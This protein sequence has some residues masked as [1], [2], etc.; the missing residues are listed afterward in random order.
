VHS[1]SY[2]LT[3]QVYLIWLLYLKLFEKV[4]ALLTQGILQSFPCD[5]QMPAT[6]ISLLDRLYKTVV[7]ALDQLVSAVGLK[8]A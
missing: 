8:A 1:R 2:R 5:Q 6:R 3:S 4:Y 7:T